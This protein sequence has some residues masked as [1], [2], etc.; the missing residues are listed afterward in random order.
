MSLNNGRTETKSNF[1]S[2]SR[3][4]I[5]TSGR[6]GC[7]SLCGHCCWVNPAPSRT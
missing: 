6:S 4:M 1:M 5:G 3:T 2:M 7:I